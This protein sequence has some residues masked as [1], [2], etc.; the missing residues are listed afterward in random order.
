MTPDLLDDTLATL[1]RTAEAT[2]TA[3]TE[4]R[5]EAARKIA[6]LEVTRVRAYRRHHFIRLL[7]DAA[8]GAPDHAM[9]LTAQRTAAGERF[10]WSPDTTT[11][12]QREVFAALAPVTSAIA[13]I[14][15]PV[16]PGA[17]V[18]A[19]PLDLV[20]ALDTFETWYRSRFDD[21]VWKL[22]DRFTPDL[23]VTDF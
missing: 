21:S 20:A 16:D 12:Q 13:D 2:K 7:G 18:A 15:V 6:A 19:D 23:P 4:V 11:D 1:L 3:E 8:R 5:H 14:A 17:A 22:F 10:G 9:A